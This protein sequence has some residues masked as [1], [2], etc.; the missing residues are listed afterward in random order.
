MFF[1]RGSAIDRPLTGSHEQMV[2][3]GRVLLAECGPGDY[4][5]PTPRFDAAI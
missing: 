3:V 5:P 2:A 4:Q 1:G